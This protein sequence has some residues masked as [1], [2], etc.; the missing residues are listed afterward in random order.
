[1]G[2]PLFWARWSEDGNL[3]FAN[4]VSTSGNNVTVSYYD[5]TE[6]VLDKS[7]VLNAYEALKA[8]LW[9]HGNW[10]G[11]GAFYPCEIQKMN[12]ETVVVQYED[13]VVET[14]PY[15]WLVYLQK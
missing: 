14:M 9:P 5:G 11:R 1:M 10:E 13:G 2:K 3:Y 12:E 4:I 8:G 7:D 15:E 6:E